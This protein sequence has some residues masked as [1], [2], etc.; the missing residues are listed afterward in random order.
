MQMDALSLPF[1][2]TRC[3]WVLLVFH[4]LE[5][6]ARICT[7]PFHPQPT[8]PLSIQLLHSSPKPQTRQDQKK[9]KTDRRDKQ[10][11]Q[12]HKPISP[13]YFVVEVLCLIF[14]S[15]LPSFL[16]SFLVLLKAPLPTLQIFFLSSFHPTNTHTC[17]RLLSSV[18]LLTEWMNE[19]NGFL[20]FF[21]PTT[22]IS[23][24]VGFL[25]VFLLGEY[26]VLFEGF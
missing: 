10:T 22:T 26:W 2:C 4:I 15:E 5:E 20:S 21:A 9:Q 18:L 23:F 25:F 1:S 3:K 16:P 19:W 14:T 12:K 13:F 17:S 8:H 11:S 7:S 24:V 6:S